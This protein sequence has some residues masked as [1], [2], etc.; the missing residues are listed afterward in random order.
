M[1]RSGQR[2][3]PVRIH[4]IGPNDYQSRPPAAGRGERSSVPEPATLS[5][6]GLALVGIGVSRRRK[7]K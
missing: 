4:N 5:L 2:R 3:R 7:Q 1:R 6:I